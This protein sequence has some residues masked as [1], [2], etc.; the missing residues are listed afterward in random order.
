M[1]QTLTK[2]GIA[3]EVEALQDL[4]GLMVGG[5]DSTANALTIMLLRMKRNPESLKKLK[6]EIEEHLPTLGSDPKK[7]GELVTPEKIDELEYLNLFIKE[8]LRI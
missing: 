4:L 3:N 2:D 8:C 7:F 6:D 5:M 1:Y